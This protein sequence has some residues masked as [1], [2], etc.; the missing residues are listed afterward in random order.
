MN[1]ELMRSHSFRNSGTWHK[2]A[3]EGLYLYL[4]TL[5][6]LWWKTYLLNMSLRRSSMDLC[7]NNGPLLP[8]NHQNNRTDVWCCRVP[9]A[10]TGFSDLITV[11]YNIWSFKLISWKCCIMQTADILM[12]W[13]F[14]MHNSGKL[15]ASQITNILKPLE[16]ILHCVSNNEHRGLQHLMTYNDAISTIAFHP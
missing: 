16:T 2:F 14:C 6:C 10:P 13:W 4:H 15:N 7:G 3:S 12:V 9:K 11:G 1:W 5:N 8:G